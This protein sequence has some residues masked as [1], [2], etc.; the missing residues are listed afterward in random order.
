MNVR[1]EIV[2][3][4]SFDHG[5]RLEQDAYTGTVSPNT[6]GQSYFRNVDVAEDGHGVP[7]PVPETLCFGKNMIPSFGYGSL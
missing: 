3:V 2:G 1:G 7:E 4:M 5:E 6:R